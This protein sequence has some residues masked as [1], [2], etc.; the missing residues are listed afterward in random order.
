V[1]LS[2]YV[3]TVANDLLQFGE[4][5]S[6][7]WV[8]TCTDDEFV[9]VCAAAEFVW[10]QGPVSPAGQSMTLAK[11]MAI[12]AV[13]VHEGSPRKMVKERRD[14][15]RQLPS[16]SG[17]TN[18]STD[19]W[20][21][22]SFDQ[23]YGVGDD[24]IEFWARSPS[25]AREFLTKA[26]ASPFFKRERP[27][28]IEEL[29][30]IVGETITGIRTLSYRS[31][32][33]K[34]DLEDNNT[35]ELTFRGGRVVRLRGDGGDHLQL[36]FNAWRDPFEVTQAGLNAH[37]LVRE[38]GWE[39]F[40]MDQEPEWTPLTAEPITSVEILRD[41][42]HGPTGARLHVNKHVVAVRAKAQKFTVKLDGRSASEWIALRSE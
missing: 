23:F 2:A 18:R 19:V 35:L 7:H 10:S 11:A 3:Y 41:S 31:P 25:E 9:R 17:G 21:Q 28:A 26:R 12:G 37:L 36:F 20:L 16:R 1:A 24:F 42:R 32:K 34:L 29:E 38:G 15:K 6:A 14:T 30:T 8:E 39:A 4:D 22:H 40:G 27:P 33:G 13:Y 5:D